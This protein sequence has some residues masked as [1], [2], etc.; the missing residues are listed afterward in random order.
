MRWENWPRSDITERRY[1]AIVAAIWLQDGSADL[2]KPKLRRGKP[3]EEVCG[4]PPLASAAR[5]WPPL[6]SAGLRAWLILA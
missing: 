3:R 6:A 4:C 5:R 1:L 2:G